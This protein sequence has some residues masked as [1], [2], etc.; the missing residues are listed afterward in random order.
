M[1]AIDMDDL[2][3][4]R[5]EMVQMEN[6]DLTARY[7]VEESEDGDWSA[8]TLTDEGERV[9]A[10]EVIESAGSLIREGLADKYNEMAAE[11]PMVLVIVPDEAFDVTAD[12]IERETGP[13]VE[14]RSYSDMGLVVRA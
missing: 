5:I 4:Q 13:T 12:L 6:P 11:A 3:A 9:V 1:A 10:I 8:I 14:L 2:T 7:D